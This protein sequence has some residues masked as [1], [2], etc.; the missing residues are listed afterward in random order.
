MP[1]CRRNFKRSFI[2]EPRLF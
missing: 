1:S 2:L